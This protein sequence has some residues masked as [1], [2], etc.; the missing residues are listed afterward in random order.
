MK[1]R[2]KERAAA[3]LQAVLQKNRVLLASTVRKLH[4]DELGVGDVQLLGEFGGGVGGVGG[5]GDGA[6]HGDRHE[7]EPKPLTPFG[8][9]SPWTEA[10][11]SHF[12]ASRPDGPRP[13]HLFGTGFERTAA[14]TPLWLRKNRVLLASTVRKLHD[15][16]LGVGDV[17][18]LGEF[19]GGVGG[20]GGG[21]DGAEHGDRHEGEDELRGV[22]EERERERVV[23][24]GA[25]RKKRVR[26]F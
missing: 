6:E 23:E 11:S 8:T 25:G 18:L 12:L 19:G 24:A 14:Y 17:Q 21:G 22:G 4:D 5:G 9:S 13:K 26:D 7:E 16:E 2:K 20:V 10:Y 1:T 3:V 15:D